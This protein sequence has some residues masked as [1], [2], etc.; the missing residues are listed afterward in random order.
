MTTPYDTYR[1]FVARVEAFGEAIRERYAAQLM[2]RAG[3]DHC[4]Y[5]EFTVFP[6]EAHHLAQAI[7][8][9]SLDERQRLQERLQQAERTLPIA[10]TLQPCVL[11]HE[12][13]C[14]VYGG[15]PLICRLQGF[16]LFSDMI[17]RPDGSQR[18]CCPLNFATMSLSDVESTAIF[19]LDLVNQT[20]AA[21]HHLYVQDA[22]RDSGQR[23]AR[24]H[25]SEAVRDALKRLSAAADAS[26]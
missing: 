21:I 23:Q 1:Q 26:P 2:C 10:E 4:C 11:L 9:L 15:R 22:G 16:P 6:V 20:L 12:G 8:A 19:N 18:D 14:S 17:E 24:V 3:C 7:A 25:L 5:Q 13:R